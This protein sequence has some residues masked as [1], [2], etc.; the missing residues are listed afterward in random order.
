MSRSAPTNM[1]VNPATKYLNWNSEKGQ[2]EYWDKEN[3]KNVA[4]PLP[5][6]FL[7][8]DQLATIKGFSDKH[9]GGMWSN[10]VKYLKEQKLKVVGKA[11]DG[12]LFQI[13]EGLYPDIKET[14][15]TAGGK[16]TRSLYT[17]MLNDKEEYEIVNFQLKGAAFSGW[18]DFEKD[19][20]NTVLSDEIICKDFKREKKGAT[21]YTIPIFSSQPASEEGNEAAMNLDI[22]LQEYL[23]AY[24]E[25]TQKNEEYVTDTLVNSDDEETSDTLPF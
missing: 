10:E 16:Y 8:L 24:F 22:Q 21:K 7:V 13:A 19:N 18:L 14:V 25:K 12:K 5:I 2:F 20:R 23:T 6:S 11:K 3:K 1:L 9:Q 4:V 17:A 15:V